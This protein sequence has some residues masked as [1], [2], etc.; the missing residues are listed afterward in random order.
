MGV[1]LSDSLIIVGEA[2]IPGLKNTKLLVKML[3]ELQRE[4]ESMLVVMNMYKAHLQL[5]AEELGREIQTSIKASLPDVLGLA[6]TAIEKGV[7]IVQLQPNC[8][9]SRVITKM[10]LWQ[11]GEKQVFENG[12]GKKS[13]FAFKK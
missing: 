13:R 12:A 3:T 7:P 6:K 5:S 10:A 11:M 9:F 2:T 1:D 4:K 8:E